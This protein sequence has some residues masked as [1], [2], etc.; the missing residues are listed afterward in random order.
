MDHALQIVLTVV[1]TVVAAF[2]VSLILQLQKTA[3]AVQALAES[4]RVDARQITEDVHQ[5]RLQ[6]DRTAA[7]VE[8]TLEGPATAGLMASSA[9]RGVMGLFGRG[10]GSLVE[11]LVTALRIGLDFIRRRRRAAHRKE[12]NDE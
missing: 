8:R 12:K 9:L 2:L 6:V 11:G 7:L 1:I 3:Q 5:V 4:L 10:A